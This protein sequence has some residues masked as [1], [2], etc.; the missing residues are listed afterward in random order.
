MSNWS[1]TELFNMYLWNLNII[2]IEV[3]LSS[4]LN[5]CDSQGGITVYFVNCI[6]SSNFGYC[7][8]K[9]QCWSEKHMYELQW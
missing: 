9:R 5:M 8:R 3:L 4:S 6:Y 2:I 7:I 1:A